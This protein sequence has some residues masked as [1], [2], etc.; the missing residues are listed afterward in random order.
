MDEVIKNIL[1]T[2]L[3]IRHFMKVFIYIHIL[4][5]IYFIIYIYIHI[6]YMYSKL[7]L[8]INT[9]LQLSYAMQDLFNYTSQL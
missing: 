1:I 7:K 9:S 4:T 8:S 6:Y 3:L 2:Q 5:S